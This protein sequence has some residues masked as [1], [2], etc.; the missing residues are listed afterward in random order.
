MTRLAY[1]R[2]GKSE[3]R[4][5]KLHRGA[6]GDA[7]SDV[8]VAVGL[9]GDVEA[10]YRD[11]DN[12]SVV[13]TDTM[14][15]TVY[16]LAQEHLG[17]DVE[18]FATTI[19]RHFLAKEGVDGASVALRQHRWT[20][21]TGSGFIG[22][23]SEVRTAR[24]EVSASA[25]ATWGGVDG[26]AVLKTSGSAF[27]GFPKDRYTTLPDKDDRVLATTI[28]AE[29]RYGVVPADTTATWDRVRGI[30][31]ER[32]FED[33]SASVQHQGWMMGR[34]VLDDVA[35]VADIELRL[36]NQHHLD[37]DLGRFGL[38]DAGIVF[39][40]VDEPYGDIAFTLER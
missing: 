21:V 12:S 18:A 25:E 6:D 16:V 30:L 11:G 2:W 40:P 10:A 31:L 13:P 3:V 8:T 28:T 32:F 1:E 9:T 7:F 26:L 35:E 36:P 17:S 5:S 38:D 37:V 14:K 24:T 33:P 23:S 15:N 4:V 22:D 29:W 39:Q 27:A 34:A 20:R 19:A